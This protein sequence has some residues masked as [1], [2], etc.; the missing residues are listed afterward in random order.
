M[1]LLYWKVQNKFGS[2]AGLRTQQPINWQ[3]LLFSCARKML[4][5]TRCH[6]SFFFYVSHNKVIFIQLAVYFPFLRNRKLLQV[7]KSKKHQQEKVSWSC[8]SV[9]DYVESLENKNTKE[10]TECE[11]GGKAFEK[12]KE[13]QARGATHR[14]RRIK[15]APCRLHLFCERWLKPLKKWWRRIWIEESDSD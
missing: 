15:Q 13:W 8:T 7:L 4:H 6:L 11:I 1:Y 3:L 5:L 9:K 12:Q 10:K 14:A 2:Q